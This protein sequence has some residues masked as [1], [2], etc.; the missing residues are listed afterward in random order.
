MNTGPPITA[1]MMPTGMTIGANKV[2]PM[3]SAATIKNAPQTA[4][5]G[6]NFR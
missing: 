1:N 5:A 4:D 2:R 6:N 3:V